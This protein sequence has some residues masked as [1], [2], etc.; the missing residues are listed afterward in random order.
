MWGH[1]FGMGAG[2]GAFGLVWMLIMAAFWIGLIAL[3]VF[4]VMRVFRHMGLK[5]HDG[6]FHGGH[7]ADT[8]LEILKKRYAAGEINADEYQQKKRTCWIENKKLLVDTNPCVIMGQANRAGI[9][10][11]MPE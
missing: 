8:A 5:M 7:R 10:C 1:G 2:W 3:I 9:T 4:V 6:G 11:P